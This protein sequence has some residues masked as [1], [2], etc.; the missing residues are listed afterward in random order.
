MSVPSLTVLRGGEFSQDVLPDPPN[1]FLSP[2]PLLS[3]CTW[4]AVR[5]HHRLWE[6]WSHLT[7]LRRL[8]PGCHTLPESSFLGLGSLHHGNRIGSSHSVPRWSPR[9]CLHGARTESCSLAHRFT[10]QALIAYLGLWHSPKDFS[11]EGCVSLSLVTGLLSRPAQRDT[12]AL[13]APRR[14]AVSKAIHSA[15]RT[16]EGQMVWKTLPVPTLVPLGLLRCV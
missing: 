9:L 16:G 13:P 5:F 2:I 12:R 1:Q 10:V 14:L 7:L 3:K 4:R 6:P 15:I 11:A 8:R